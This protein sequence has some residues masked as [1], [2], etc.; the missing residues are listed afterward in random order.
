MSFISV[1]Y[2][3]L[4]KRA[5]S[6]R[7]GPNTQGVGFLH[8]TYSLRSLGPLKTQT[9]SLLCVTKLEDSCQ[10]VSCGLQSRREHNGP[11]N[12]RLPFLCS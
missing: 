9:L 1:W 6:S 10:S 5:K 11:R 3:P 4:S 12:H 7:A 8:D 2:V